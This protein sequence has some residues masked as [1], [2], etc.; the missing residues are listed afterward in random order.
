MYSNF[1]GWKKVFLIA[2]LAISN[3][4]SKIAKFGIGFNAIDTLQSNT[5]ESVIWGY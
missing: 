1:D 5:P 4:L 2:H 3:L